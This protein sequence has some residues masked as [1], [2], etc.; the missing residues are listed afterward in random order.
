MPIK[1]D[2]KGNRRVEMEV[3]VPGTPEQVWQAIATGEGNAS[4]FTKAE[5]E[6]R[7]G[8]T[9]RFDF[10]PEMASSGEV[11]IWEPPHRFGYVEKEWMPGAPPIAT[12][13]TITGRAG[14]KCVLRMVHSLFS[15][16][17]DW[18]DQMEGFEGG[19]PAFFAV[20]RIYLQHYAGKPGASLRVMKHIKGDHRE[21]FSRLMG[22]LGLS[23]IN[24]DDQYRLP[25]SPQALAGVVEQVQQTEQQRY[26]MLRLNEPAPGVAIIGTYGN[27][28]NVSLSVIAF[29]YGEDA[30]TIAEANEG[31]WRDWLDEKFGGYPA[32]KMWCVPESPA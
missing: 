10:G 28:E 20:L 21:V 27:A 5:I 24:V 26:V 22:E 25:A 19:W 18:D 11:T 6:G 12:E 14:D 31:R 29:F 9:L 1:K 8:G 23:G 7:V 32:G 3:L 16:D 30:S 15:S 4:W 2:D 17:D 13:V